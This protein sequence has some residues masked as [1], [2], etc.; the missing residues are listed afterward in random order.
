MSRRITLGVLITLVLT[1]PSPCLASDLY[2]ADAQT[3][4]LLRQ[5]IGSGDPMVT[6]FTRSLATVED[7]AEMLS[8][9]TIAGLGRELSKFYVEKGYRVYLR[10]VNEGQL[11]EFYP[12]ALQILDQQQDRIVVLVFTPN[13]DRYVHLFNTELA[14]RLGEEGVRLVITAMIADNADKATP[15]ERV[16]GSIISL[17][18]GIVRTASLPRAPELPSTDAPA[19]EV[20][21]LR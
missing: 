20:R 6:T 8:K 10:T 14:D 7:H 3:H 12:S 15:E 5:K 4:D 13:P 2:V 19:P 21:T 18:R 17:V 11:V 1:G 9:R 16:I